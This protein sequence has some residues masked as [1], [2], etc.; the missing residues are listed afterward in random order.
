MNR[1]W[2][3]VRVAVTGGLLVALVHYWSACG[4]GSGVPVRYEGNVSAVTKKTTGPLGAVEPASRFAFVRS[5]IPRLVSEAVAQSS[6]CTAPVKNVLACAGTNH[7]I[8]GDGAF[9]CGELFFRCRPIETNGEQ[10]CDFATDIRVLVQG[11]LTGLFFVQDDNANGEWDVDDGDCNTGEPRATLQDAPQ[12][13]CNGDVIQAAN[14][15]VDFTTGQA[16]AEE[17]R[18]SVNACPSD[19]PTPTPAEPTPIP[20]LPQGTSCAADSPP[21][22]EGLT[23]NMLAGACEP[24]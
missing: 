23:C 8:D 7:D 6:S 24:L 19:L 12:P 17:S 1:Y 14:I 3:S 10:R 5:L 18:K 22:C 21:C 11:D 4:D 2:R 15:S 16:V 13:V 20:C 9:D